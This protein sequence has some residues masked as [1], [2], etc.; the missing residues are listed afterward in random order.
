MKIYCTI[1]TTTIMKEIGMRAGHRFAKI[2][3]AARAAVE[4]RIYRKNH[5]INI[6][7]NLHRRATAEEA[8]IKM[9]PTIITQVESHIYQRRQPITTHIPLRTDQLIILNRRFPIHG[10]RMIP[11]TVDTGHLAEA[12]MDHLVAAD[13][14]LLI[15]IVH[16]TKA[17]Q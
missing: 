13:M 15:T 4:S 10:R 3:A 7:R 2:V 6:S 9:M 17:Q 5:R 11:E 12:A 8:T 16:H 1:P 14:V